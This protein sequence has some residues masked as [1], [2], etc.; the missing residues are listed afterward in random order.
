MNPYDEINGQGFQRLPATEFYT[1]KERE[2]RQ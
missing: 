1:K 2:A